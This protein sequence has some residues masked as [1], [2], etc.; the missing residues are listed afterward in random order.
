MKLASNLPRPQTFWWCLLSTKALAMACALGNV[1]WMPRAHG[2]SSV[3]DSS[4]L[5]YPSLE[6]LSELKTL[7]SLPP[8]AVLE[9][10]EEWRQDFVKELSTNQRLVSDAALLALE[11]LLKGDRGS[12]RALKIRYLLQASG[13]SGFPSEM[14]QALLP[15]QAK[16]LAQLAGNG[17]NPSSG[18]AEVRLHP[19]WWAQP[20]CVVAVNGVVTVRHGHLAAAQGSDF[21]VQRV[22]SDPQHNRMANGRVPPGR[23]RV[24]LAFRTNDSP[25]PT[26]SIFGPSARVETSV[27]LGSLWGHLGR[28][29]VLKG[30]LPL[31]QGTPLLLGVRLLATDGWSIQLAAARTTSRNKSGGVTQDAPHPN[32]Q[33]DNLVARALVEKQVMFSWLNPSAPAPWQGR[34]GPYLGL[35]IAGLHEQGQSLDT[36]AYLAPTV[37]AGLEAQL[38][39]SLDD[40]R[41]VAGGLRAGWTIATPPFRGITR[42]VAMVIGL[43]F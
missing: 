42:E 16:R 11:A 41:S 38:G 32:V 5:A 33:R 19:Y 22:C 24:F 2:S 4:P 7:Q 15:H 14:R 25:S 27:L 8:E 17:A 1:T 29:S 6:R 12:A 3:H 23:D 35:G 9:R 30:D 28:A 36:W 40:R 37:S 13:R 26:F 39:W 21:Y 10:L 34:A 31:G 18:L 20:S 43:T